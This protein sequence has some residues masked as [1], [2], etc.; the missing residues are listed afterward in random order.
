MNSGHQII[1]NNVLCINCKLYDIIYA[2]INLNVSYNNT[3][4]LSSDSMILNR[5]LFVP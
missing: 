4:V 1:K 2:V 3:I 5:L